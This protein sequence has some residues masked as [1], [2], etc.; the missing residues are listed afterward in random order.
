MTLSWNPQTD[1][2]EAADGLEAVT[3]TAASGA[4][5][6]VSGALRLRIS[7]REAAAS[8]GRYTRSDVRWHLP[9]S[10][11]L[12]PPQMGAT[13]ADGQGQTWTILEVDHDTRSSRW[14]CWCRLL[15]LSVVLDDRI[16]VQQ[17]T[18]NKDDHGALVPT[19]SNWK[20]D[21]PARV[22]PIEAE[23]A[24]RHEQRYAR[25]TH[26]VYVAQSLEVNQNH[27]LLHPA[28]GTALHVIGYEKPERIDALLAIRA[29]KTPWLLS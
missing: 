28:T 2:L 11:V 14:R 18:W 21:L 1:F 26:L 19:W 4:T 17:A 9:A 27:R 22:Q 6:A 29:T 12:S 7:Q 23:I 5:T 24:A 10:Q 13:I 16:H 25:V 3:L 20:P 8:G 15:G